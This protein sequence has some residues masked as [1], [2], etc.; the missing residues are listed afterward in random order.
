MKL[1]KKN[2]N[3]RNLDGIFRLMLLIYVKNMKK[4]VSKF[5]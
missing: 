4:Y 2:I 5:M 3:D 1:G